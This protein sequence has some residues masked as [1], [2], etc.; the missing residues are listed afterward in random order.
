MAKKTISFIRA[1]MKN[2]D[3][4][5]M[6][7]TGPKGVLTA[8]PMSNNGDVKYDGDS[9]FFSYEGSQKIEDIEKDTSVNLSFIA[10]N[11]L[12]IA[13]EGKAKLIRS[14]TAMKPHWVSS[15]NTWFKDGLDTE[16]IVLIKVSAKKIKYWDRMEQGEIPL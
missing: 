9:Y 1:K 3:I 12:Y 2:L 14:K 13:V 11:D 5:M 10:S 8:R 6:T 7:T 15:L 4:C 16:G